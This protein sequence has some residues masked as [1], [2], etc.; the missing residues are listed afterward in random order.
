MNFGSGPLASARNAFMAFGGLTV[1]L[2]SRPFA[3]SVQAR[4][5]SLRPVNMPADYDAGSSLF[6]ERDA[7]TDAF[8]A[9][10]C[11]GSWVLYPVARTPA[12][13]LR[14][15]AGPSYIRYQ[16]KEFTPAAAPTSWG[17]FSFGRPSNY[18]SRTNIRTA[19]GVEGAIRL[20]GL[21]RRLGGSGGV[22]MHAS[23]A[24]RAVGIDLAILLGRLR[25]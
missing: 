10:G 17:W 24:F 19:V 12:F 16:Q 15:E 4:Y 23:P 14:L 22:W 1:Q 8:V 13:R 3:V 6:G 2:P 9:V 5:A 21:G 7:P 18:E 25:P 11:T 20:E